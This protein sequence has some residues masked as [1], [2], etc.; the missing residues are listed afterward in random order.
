MEATAFFGSRRQ[1]V[2]N[3][4][5]PQNLSTPRHISFRYPSLAICWYMVQ[6]AINEECPPADNNLPPLYCPPRISGS[7]FLGL[8]ITT[9]FAFAL[10]ARFSVASMPFHSKSCGLMPWATIC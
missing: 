7:P 8:P 3:A 1:N 6:T 9:T 10:L 4:N 5:A 2:S